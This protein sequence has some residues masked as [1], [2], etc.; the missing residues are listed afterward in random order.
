LL[1]LGLT[2]PTAD[3]QALHY[4]FS[5]KGTTCVNSGT[6][7]SDGNMVIYT[8]DGGIADHHDKNGP[9]GKPCLALSTAT[10]MGTGFV[11]P[12]AKGAAGIVFDQAVSFTV[13]GWYQA[14]GT[15]ENIARIFQAGPRFML[16]FVGHGLSLQTG[17]GEQ[18]DSVSSTTGLMEGGQG[19]TVPPSIPLSFDISYEWV[20]FAVTYENTRQ[21][22]RV[23]FY[24]GD[25]DM[26]KPL[27][28]SVVNYVPAARE[29]GNTQNMTFG[30]SDVPNTRPFRGL[31]ADIRVYTSA[32]NGSAALNAAEVAKLRASLLSK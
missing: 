16:S 4:K 10:G 11:G 22:T 27:R 8:A 32:T 9:A 19:K 23:T 21:G 31:L 18:I 1:G 15:P 7:G 14:D 6:M 25:A 3:A 29:L 24:R 5:E 17:E 12:V 26:T 30:G 28:S 13:S 2:A 20:F